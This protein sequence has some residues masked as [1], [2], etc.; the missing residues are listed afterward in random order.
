M[1]KDEIPLEPRLFKK[2]Q[3][4]NSKKPMQIV[5]LRKAKKL[6]DLVQNYTNLFVLLSRPISKNQTETTQI[7]DYAIKKG[8]SIIYSQ[9]HSS[10]WEFYLYFLYN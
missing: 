7:C 4:M 9:K 8:L 1:F 2:A 6:I 10:I 5:R 3:E